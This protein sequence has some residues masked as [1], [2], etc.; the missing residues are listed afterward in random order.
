M[1]CTLIPTIQISPAPPQEHFPEPYSPF[2]NLSFPEPD[3]NTFRPIHLT[4]PTTHTSFAKHL[5]PLCPPDAPV[6][7]K[8]LERERFEA[9]LRASKERNA[10]VGAKK[11]VDLR[12][13]IAHKAHRNK[14]GMLSNPSS[15]FNLLTVPLQS[16]DVPSS[17]P[18]SRRRPPQRQQS[19]QR[20]P[21]NPPLFFIT[22]SPL[23]GLFPHL[24]CLIHSMTITTLPC[25]H[26]I[27]GSNKSTSVFPITIRSK[28]PEAPFFPGKTRQLKCCH[29][30]TKSL[31]A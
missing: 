29:L 10:L 30:W 18:R 24:L 5:S 21:P 11:A 3:N 12:K 1:A 31:L 6:T 23:Q 19:L 13:E 14:L 16:N 4:P 27:H 25:I 8:G 26:V 9:L 15:L 17:S 22:L 7:N 2:C 20:H 28:S